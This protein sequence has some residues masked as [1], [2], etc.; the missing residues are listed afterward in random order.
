MIDRAIGGFPSPSVI[1]TIVDPTA[2]PELLIYN[3][4]DGSYYL[5]TIKSPEIVEE[6]MRMLGFNA[7]LVEKIDDLEKLANCKVVVEFTFGV[8][9]AVRIREIA[10]RNGLIVYLV[11]LKDYYDEKTTNILKY[12][13]NG[14]I[15]VEAEKIGERFVYRF[16]IPKMIGGNSLSSYIRF[17][18]ERS[19]LE[20]DTSRDIV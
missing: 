14:I 2:S 7:I 13:C 19:V 17:K 15:I 8:D 1:L 12:V 18:T 16:A 9:E 3:L 10:M 5:P 4:S 6:E 20:I 11:V